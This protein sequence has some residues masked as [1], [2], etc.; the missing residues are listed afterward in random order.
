MGSFSKNLALLLIGVWLGM[1][2][3]FGAAVAPT[4]FNNDVA[5]GISREMRGAITGSLIRLIFKATYIFLGGA[6]FFLMV[7]S[8]GES[9][10]AKGPRRALLC[11]IL[12]LGLN[13]LDH[14]WIAEKMTKLRLQIDNPN[15][16]ASTAVLQAEWDGW[17]KKSEYVYKGAV[18]FGFLGGLLL[19]PSAAPAKASKGRKK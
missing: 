16:G 1:A 8:F 10:G 12:A 14:L 18:I 5:V 13:A 9:R 2:L 11:C 19:L 7:T 4:V 6:I 17:H 3:F 15:P